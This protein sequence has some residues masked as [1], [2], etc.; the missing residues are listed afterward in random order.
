MNNNIHVSLEV[1]IKIILGIF[2]MNFTGSNDSV[3]DYFKGV[4]VLKYICLYVTSCC[5]KANRNDKN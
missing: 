2:I 1:F 4:S 5:V 3:Q